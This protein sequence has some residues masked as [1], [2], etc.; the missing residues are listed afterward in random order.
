MKRIYRMAVLVPGVFLFLGGLG[1]SASLKLPVIDGKTVLATVNGEPLTREEMEREMFSLHEGISDNVTRSRSNPSELL[2]RMIDAMLIV[3]EARNIGLDELPEVQDAIDGF[4]K[5]ILRSMLFGSRM[6]TLRKPD[7]KDVEKR[8]REAVK[9]V[10]V[11]S[12]FLDREDDAKTLEREV[13]AGSDFSARAKQ[14]IEEGG[15]KGSTDGEYVK[16]DALLPEVA[17]VISSMKKGEVGP[18]IKI[19]NRF[20]MVKLEDFRYPEDPTAREKAEKEALQAKQVKALKAYTEGLMKQYVKAHENL[21]ESLDY[22]SAE[23]GFDQLSKD[24]RVLAEIRG[25]KNVTV[26][27]LTEALRK[28]FFHGAEKAAEK[29]RINKRKDLVLDEILIKQVL[30][31]EAK[32]RKLDQTGYYGTKVAE[33]RKAVLFGMFIQKVVIPEV[34]VNEEEIRAYRQ[35]HIAEYTSSEMMQIDGIA[36]SRKTDAEDVIEK[37]RKGSDFQWVRENTEGQADPYKTT[38]YL[39]FGGRTME[40]ARL[41]EGVKKIV[42]GASEG[43]YRLYAPAG[44][45]YYVLQVRKVFPPRPQA[46][47]EV[48]DGIAKILFEKKR[49]RSVKEWLEKLRA[50]SDVKIFARG[51]ALRRI[52]QTPSR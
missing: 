46:L 43:E 39:E 22:E 44:G 14:M 49:D 21:L 9:E 29:K 17:T 31:M 30:D 11:L 45:P 41:P 51:D 38:D 28:K 7:P 52:L 42:D 1:Y 12:V 35:E 5:D 23:P 4:Q 18:L 26:A 24:Q 50:A 36:Y 25:G 33:Y 3:Q 48:R 13:K 2:D 47:E 10:K 32:S 15:A 16:F 8:Y 6:R 19:G 20:V 40:T 34:R 37:L 27:D